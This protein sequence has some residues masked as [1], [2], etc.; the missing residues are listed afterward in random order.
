MPLRRVFLGVAVILNVAMPQVAWSQ[1]KSPPG[2]TTPSGA[3]FDRL[4]DATTRSS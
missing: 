4:H 3:I 1:M 2:G